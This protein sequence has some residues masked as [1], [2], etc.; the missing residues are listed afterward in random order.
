VSRLWAASRTWLPTGASATP[1]EKEPTGIVVVTV[2]VTVSERF[3][4][5]SNLGVESHC[6][7]RRLAPMPSTTANE[8]NHS[9]KSCFAD[10]YNFNFAAMIANGSPERAKPPRWRSLPAL[11]TEEPVDVPAL[12]RRI[13][14]MIED[15]EH[16]AR[17]ARTT[18]ART[19]RTA[20]Q[21]RKARS[22]IARVAL[23][24]NT[25][26]KLAQGRGGVAGERK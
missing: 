20:S 13:R 18:T 19:A 2:L 10:R 15:A 26:E 16:R 4:K 12:H 6:A 23:I 21:N 5:F 7:L 25:V 24:K 8:I 14:S 1:K 11:A 22:C 3:V 17:H 9:R